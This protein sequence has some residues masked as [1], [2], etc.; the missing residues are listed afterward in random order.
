MAY[1][2]FTQAKK[3]IKKADKLYKNTEKTQ[4]DLQL[5]NMLEILKDY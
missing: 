2:D 3:Y 1:R 4:T 5:E